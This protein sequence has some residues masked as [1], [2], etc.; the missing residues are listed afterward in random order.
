MKG[1]KQDDTWFPP[2]AEDKSGGGIVGQKGI[3]GHSRPSAVQ[4]ETGKIIRSEILKY[5][6][7]Q[8]KRSFTHLV[9]STSIY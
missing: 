6:I 2:K 3:V 7:G 4:D 5:F 1:L 9:H 8:A